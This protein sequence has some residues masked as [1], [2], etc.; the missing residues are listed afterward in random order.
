MVGENGSKKFEDEDSPVV[1]K[2]RDNSSRL[3]A[4]E[5]LFLHASRMFCH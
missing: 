5:P 2:S 3:P 4:E 1:P